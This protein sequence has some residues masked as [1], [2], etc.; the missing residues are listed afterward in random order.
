M[1]HAIELTHDRRVDLGVLRLHLHDET[2]RVEPERP[3]PRQNVDAAI[4][5][6]RRNLRD[7]SLALKYPSDQVRQPVPLESLCD[8]LPDYI[9][10]LLRYVGKRLV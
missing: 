6:G 5:S 3:S 10:G 9:V 4:R 2:W 8:P 7:V 1:H